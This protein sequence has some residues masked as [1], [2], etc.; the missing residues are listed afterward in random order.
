MRTYLVQV[1]ALLAK[2]L[3]IEFRTRDTLTAILIFALLVLVTFNFALDIRP[4]IADAVGPGILWI[5]VVFTG[6]VGIGR[7]FSEERDRGTLELLVSSP[8]DRS[9][10]FLSKVASSMAIMVA[11]QGLLVPAFVGLFNVQLE[12]GAIVPVLLLGD[13][14]LAAVTTLL[15][16]MAA[17]TRARE[18]LLP[19]LIFPIIVPLLIA[20]VQATS[21]VLGSELARDRPWLGLLVAFDAI[22]LSLGVAVFE[23]VVEE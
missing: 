5:A 18:V 19:V 8:V 20:V 6:P 1:C 17:H 4:E 15:S 2:D 10:I 7:T 14:G 9:A 21:L 16:A 11:A 23:Y 13:L 22:Y 3:Q 12:P